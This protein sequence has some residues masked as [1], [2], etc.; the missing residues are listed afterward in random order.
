MAKIEA[1]RVNEPRD[2]PTI[3]GRWNRARSSIG[4]FW[5]HSPTMKT[6]ISTTEPTSIDT[7]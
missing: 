5:R 6:A 3:A 1:D 2:T 7:M 4:S